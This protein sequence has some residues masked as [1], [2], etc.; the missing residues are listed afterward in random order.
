MELKRKS[1]T[2]YD[3][4]GNAIY[5]VNYDSGGAVTSSSLNIY[6]GDKLVELA[7]FDMNQTIEQRTSYTFFE[8]QDLIKQQI[9]EYYSDGKV[10]RKEIYEWEYQFYD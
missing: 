3:N 9:N 6:S 7:T 10:D 8:E 4:D 1:I 5:K 2:Y